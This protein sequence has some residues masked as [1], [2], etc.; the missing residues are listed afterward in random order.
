MSFTGILSQ[1]M[2]RLKRGGHACYQIVTALI[3]LFVLLV[4]VLLPLGLGS[5]E[6]TIGIQTVHKPCNRPIAPWLL[7]LGGIHLSNFA[8]SMFLCFIRR[9]DEE[10]E[11][12]RPFETWLVYLDESAIFM[13]LTSQVEALVPNLS[14][15]HA[16][17]W[18]RARLPQPRLR[19]DH[20]HLRFHNCCSWHSHS[21]PRYC[22][23]LDF[24]LRVLRHERVQQRAAPASHRRHPAGLELPRARGA[25]RRE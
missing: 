2:K 5:V 3:L 7:V 21:R 14:F 12:P 20:V 17:R 8:L 22:C 18:G 4:L 24:D 16:H 15:F 9:H 19:Q 13:D 25:A 11:N 10:N 23:R 6:L 1:I